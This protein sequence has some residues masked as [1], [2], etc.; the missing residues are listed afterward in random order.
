MKTCFLFP[1]VLFA[2]IFLLFQTFMVHDCFEFCSRLVNH[3]TFF[4]SKAAISAA[5]RFSIF[6]ATI[7]QQHEVAPGFYTSR[8]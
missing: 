7:L 4:L 8:L 1:Q 5:S 6:Y 3:I 2:T